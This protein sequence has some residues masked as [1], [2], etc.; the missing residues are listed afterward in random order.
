MRYFFFPIL[1][2]FIF[3]VS[4]EAIFSYTSNKILEDRT[5]QM[6]RTADHIK[7]YLFN[8]KFLTWVFSGS[9]ALFL[10]RNLIDITNFKA[11]RVGKHLLVKSRKALIDKGKKIISLQDHVFVEFKKNGKYIRIK[12]S[13]AFVDLTK[14]I[15]YGNQNVEVWEPDR[16][17]K[18]VGFRYNIKTGSFIILRDVKTIFNIS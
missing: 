3:L 11:Y 6:Q 4:Y 7:V 8:K 9:Q 1:L 18:G 5:K 14:N 16:I 17:I 12:T 15:I 13:K 2:G 10:S